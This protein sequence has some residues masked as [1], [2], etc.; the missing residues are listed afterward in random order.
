MGGGLWGRCL[1]MPC[2]KAGKSVAI[3]VEDVGKRLGGTSHSEPMVPK[4]SRFLSANKSTLQG[5][6]GLQKS[7]GFSPVKLIMALMLVAAPSGV[8]SLD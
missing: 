3:Q 7:G 4:A 5:P 6:W 2:G 1:P 8:L